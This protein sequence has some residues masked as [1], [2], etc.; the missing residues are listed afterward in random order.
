M[1]FIPCTLVNRF[2]CYKEYYDVLLL[3]HPEDHF[4][5][6][7]MHGTTPASTIIYL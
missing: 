4:E 7:F 3:N 1:H 5:K 2:G 6:R